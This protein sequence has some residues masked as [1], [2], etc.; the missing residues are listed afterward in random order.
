MARSIDTPLMRQ[1]LEIKGQHSDA[2]L[3][4]RMGDFYELFFDDAVVASG[5]LELTLTSRDR[6]K[7]DAVPMCGVPH[8]AV[9]GYIRRLLNLGHKVAICDQVEDPR[10]A[11]GLVKRAVTQIVTPGVVL[12]TEHLEAKMNNFVLAVVAEGERFGLAALDLSTFELRTTE[13]EGLVALTDEVARLQPREVLYDGQAE[14]SLAPLRDAGARDE[15]RSA[16]VELFG[17]DDAAHR[18]LEEQV[19]V[20]ADS[21]LWQMRLA[22]RASA[23]VLR[24]VA[25]TQPASG[26]PRCR[27]LPYRPRDFLQLDESTVANLEIFCSIME[28]KREGS[29]LGVV[30]ATLTAM[31]GRALRHMLAFPLL[32]VAA[33]R[34]RH[35]AVEFLV[36]E[37]TLRRNLRDALRQVYDLERLTSRTALQL[38]TPRELRRLA[39]SLR[40][41]PL[42]VGLLRQAGGASLSREIPELLAW[43]ADLLEDV[44]SAIDAALVDDPPATAGEGGVVRRGHSVEL[45]ELVRLAEGGK[46]EILAIESRERA[47]TGIGSLKVRF[48]RVF[49]YTIEVTRSN[50]RSVP[51]DYRR[52]QTLANAERFTTVELADHEAKVLGAEEKRVALEQELFEA[53]RRAVASHAARLSEAARFLA[54]LDVL[55]TFAEVAQANDYV[56]PDVDDGDVVAVEEGRHPVVERFL[57]P[58]QFVPNDVL[59]D[60]AQGRMLVLTGPNMAG[61]STVMR[62]T[63]LIVLLAQ[64]GSFVP[65]RRARIGVVDRLFTR[66]GAS[67]NLARGESTFMVEMRETASILQH[68]TS[69]SLVVLDE[70][71]RG[72]A[73]YDGISIAWAVAEYLHDRVQAKCLFAT[74]YHELCALADVKPF[75]RNFNIAVQEW[76]GKVVFLRKL[77]PGGSSRS[78]GIE[79]ARLAGLDRGV[80]ARARRVLAALESGESLEG[81]PIRGRLTE[82]VPGQLGLFS[83]ARI[84]VPAAGS[85]EAG[86]LEELKGLETDCLTPLEALNRLAELRRRLGPVTE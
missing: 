6:N 58:G 9:A 3:F 65:A 38:V 8:H 70:I 74:H 72:T 75:V 86:V 1:Y 49:G 14:A 80:I 32:E 2:L 47:R 51:P 45:D 57:P 12:D 40:Q 36:Q 83:H 78:Y 25:A 17:P 48:N 66:V 5:A 21:E 53:L 84:H 35:D 29:L 27:V 64:V 18:L 71:G 34:R 19:S 69:R 52:K 54:T 56:R 7:E 63:A 42:L 68:A 13:V 46:A 77:V 15:W 73:T 62:Q 39:D 50:L 43:P 82:E 4:F 30:D 67:D 79:V 10:F 23:A 24:Y 16:G 33:I 44:A 20:G 60:P 37:S 55:A 61:K 11:R 22:L 59:I 85:I 26:I 81:V 28:R 31:G 76:K 41:L